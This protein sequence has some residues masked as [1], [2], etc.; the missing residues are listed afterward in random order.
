VCRYVNS[1]SDAQ[2]RGASVSVASLHK[3]CD[4]QLFLNGSA[5]D[6][7]DPCGLVAWSYFNDTFQVRISRHS[8]DPRKKS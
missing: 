8:P 3:S 7:I 6:L 1:R 4:P 5:D 2:L